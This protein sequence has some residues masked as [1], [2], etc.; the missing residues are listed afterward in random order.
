MCPSDYWADWLSWAE[1]MEDRARFFDDDDRL[2]LEEHT[3]AP[4]DVASFLATSHPVLSHTP[5]MEM[6]GAGS[7]VLDLGA[8]GGA[9]SLAALAHGAECLAVEADAA[10]RSRLASLD[11]ACIAEFPAD[12]SR[13]MFDAV[14][15]AG[16]A[17][18]GLGN[19]WGIP[20]SLLHISRLLEPQGCMYLDLY[21][22]CTHPDACWAR[23]DQQNS[24]RSTFYL[25]ATAKHFGTLCERAGLRVAGIWPIPMREGTR[26][27]FAVT[28]RLSL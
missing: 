7:R 21:W 12:G 28:G 11:I 25:S 6:L 20:E 4:L 9:L 3:Q 23:F 15:V 2:V 8:G 5:L 16:G 1:C 17:I 27:L 18:P 10:L 22:R 24:A 26:S 19:A 14:I 13:G